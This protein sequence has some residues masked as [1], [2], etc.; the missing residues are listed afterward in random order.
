MALLMFA[1]VEVIALLFA[2]ETRGRVREEDRAASQGAA[3]S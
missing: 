3:R 2:P 1:V